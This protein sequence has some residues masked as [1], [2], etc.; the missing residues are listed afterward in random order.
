MPMYQHTS[1]ENLLA[2]LNF[3]FI[4]Q[5]RP[6]VNFV[7]KELL[8]WQNGDPVSDQLT[9]NEIWKEKSNLNISLYD[10]ACPRGQI[11]CYVLP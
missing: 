3:S 6:T 11:I 9:K 7:F 10:F 5:L 8:I 2:L 1:D 4:F